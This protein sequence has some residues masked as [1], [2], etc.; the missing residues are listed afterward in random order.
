MH[1]LAGIITDLPA[2]DASATLAH[3]L[4]AMG[5]RA[6]SA[7][8]T[9]SDAAAGMYAGWVAGEEPT[10][11][12]MIE[13]DG[14]TL[15]LVGE[16]FGD[17]VAEPGRPPDAAWL[18]RASRSEDE[19]LLALNG[20]C[21]GFLID[22]QR[23]RSLL[24]NDRL[25]LCRI[26]VA[27]W[28]G[29]VA[30]ASEAKA[31][32]AV[33]P[34]LRTLDVGA[35]GQFLGAG[36]VLGEGTLFKGIS[37]LLP[38][39]AWT[40]ETRG[41]VSRR[42]YFTPDALEAQEPATPE[43]FY[44]ELRETL[45]RVTPWYFRGDRRAAVSITGGFDS[46]AVVAF[47]GA[48]RDREAYTYNGMFRECFDARVGRAVAATAGFSHHVLS[49]DAEFLRQFP[50]LARQTIRVTDGTL[51][52]SATHEVFLSQRAR[53]IGSVRVTGNYGGEL[54]RGVTTFRPVQW[55]GS[56]F[57]PP[58]ATAINEAQESVAALR[59]LHPVTFSAFH[60]LPDNLF[61]RLAAAQS[62]LA[63]RTPYT[64][65]AVVAL[66]YRRPRDADAFATWRRLIADRSPELA[67]IA[68]DRAK[69]GTRPPLVA[70][71]HQAARQISFK[72]E[73]FYESGLPGWASR[74]DK[75]LV[76]HRVPPFLGSHKIHNYRRW[77][78]DELSG[79]LRDLLS[80]PG[81]VS[82]TLVGR[83][84]ALRL[85][86]EHRLGR[87]NRSQELTAL[88]TLELIRTELLSATAYGVAPPIVSSHAY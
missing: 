51:D 44:E 65:N 80:E 41:R 73:W 88:A 79:V 42:R 12:P 1:R 33:R 63:V 16:R 71:V 50:D 68:T 72:A 29:T 32:L 23:R 2:A 56:L 9:C 84:N 49:L 85:V 21:G 3:M 70:K 62:L 54:L 25:G 57:E 86:D 45:D 43:R 6:G 31:L 26:Y 14:C 13:A 78:R 87:A 61:G 67:A 52:I 81:A 60:E 46:R 8:G 40:F 37:R 19:A 11:E 20:W 77:Y 34:A 27:S 24:F 66:A 28:E 30:F 4:H 53:R 48:P 18:L 17:D 59:R 15:I 83:R 64:D 74:L 7:T 5:P 22:R 76:R 69:L 82:E 55:D 36:A 38:G 35:V 47:A 58:F 75:T 10:A 39:S